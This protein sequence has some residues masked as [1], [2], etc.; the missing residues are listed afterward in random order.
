MSR[1]TFSRRSRLTVSAEEAFRWHARPGAFERLTPP[2]EP[3]E[4]LQRAGPL[5]D[6]S[7]VV[8]SVP[9]GPARLRWVAEHREVRPG[10]GFKDVQVRGPFAHWEHEHRFEPDG[11]RSCW[12]EDRVEYELPAGAAGALLGGAHARARLE[13]LF[14]WRHAHVQAELRAPDGPRL[15]VGLTG[16]SGLLGSALGPALT[17]AGHEVAPLV[18]RPPGPGE[19]GWDP[20]S[21]RVTGGGLE[22][23]D[24]LVHLAGENVAA[25]RWSAARKQALRDS[26][27]GPTAAL[28][29]ALAGL[30]R[31]PSVLVCASAVGLYGDRG[32]EALDEDSAAGRGFLPELA[33]AWEDAAQPALAAGIRVV[34]LRFGVVLTPAG[35]AL[36]RMLPAF[37]LGGG[38]P[39]GHGRQWLP[40]VSIDDALDAVRRALHDDRLSG[41]VNVVAPGIVRQAEFARALGAALARPAVLPAPAAALRLA[42]GAMADALLLASARVTPGRLVAHGHA[43]RHPELPEALAHLLGRA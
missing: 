23:L 36:A 21:G 34:H 11:P 28:A 5:A 38:G 10:R 37:R 35:G 39:L 8:L 32:D 12:M 29:R 18:R 9:L 30:R 20:A 1:A 22:G 13:R 25:E 42:L 7:R 40:W 15:R 19:L 4:V 3:V 24:A 31:P 26:R 43:F 41:P 2:W 17:A 6:G 27:V 16:A 33:Q 14:A